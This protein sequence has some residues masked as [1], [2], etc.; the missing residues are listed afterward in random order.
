[1]SRAVRVAA[2]TLAVA[3]VGVVPAPVWAAPAGPVV[4]TVAGTGEQ[5]YTGDGGP[6]VRAG[7]PAPGAMALAPDG[8][9]YV[10]SGLRIRAVAPDGTIRTVAGTGGAGLHGDG[11]PATRATFGTKDDW[12]NGI[13]GIAL[14]PDGTLYVADTDNQRVRAIDPRTH[15]IRTVAGSGRTGAWNGSY[16][17]DDG[18]A[19]HARLSQPEDVAVGRDGTLYIAD[20]VNYRVRAVDPSRHTIRTVVGTRNDGDDGNG[21]FPRPDDSGTVA[22]GTFIEPASLAFG[23]DGTL[24]VSEPDRHRVRAVDLAANRITTYAPVEQ[25]SNPSALTVVGHTLYVVNTDPYGGANQSAGVYAVRLDG[26]PKLTPF[27]GGGP[28][29]RLGEGGSPT[30]TAF[31]GG[32][33]DVAGA[34]TGTVYVSDPGHGRVR[35]VTTTPPARARAR[36]A[37]R[38][39]GYPDRQ[40]TFGRPA[41]VAVAADGTAY[42][43]DADHAEVF[44]VD[45][46]DGDVDVVAGTTDW[47]DDADAVSGD[48]TGVRL[49]LPSDIAVTG[50]TLYVAENDRIRAVDL[51][52][53]TIDAV[54]GTDGLGWSH[55]AIG[56]HGA[57]YV[58][59]QLHGVCVH[60]PGSTSCRVI[61][62][63]QPVLTPEV[64]A[65][66]AVAVGPDGT[67][68][69]AD[70]GRIRAVDARTGHTTTIAGAYGLVPEVD[71]DGGPA[72]TTGAL[73]TAG[74]AVGADGIL[75][76]ADA[77]DSRI[78]AV[79][80]RTGTITTVAGT[81]RYRPSPGNRIL[82]PDSA[83]LGGGYGG[84]GGPARRAKLDQ[85]RD[86]AVGP[87]GALYVADTGNHRI[88]AV[89]DVRVPPPGIPLGW[90]LAGAAVLLLAA[91]V[92]GY[93]RL[94]RRRR[95]TPD[96]AGDRPPP[97]DDTPSD[98]PPRPRADHE[99]H[100]TAM[101]PDG[102]GMAGRSILAD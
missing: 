62:D 6:A 76:V 17:G 94:R 47:P 69:V 31:L 64:R 97:G 86:V 71:A 28:A 36:D 38:I 87:H 54:P 50:H 30:A 23:P 49:D 90:Y 55:V 32:T 88:R 57:L 20:R 53:G 35:A 82:V 74:L 91:L 61:A 68:Y 10:V 92:A 48:A 58:S 21:F 8:T 81:G 9:L 18:P 15:R 41:A 1:M 79:D 99:S 3:L 40:A 65:P 22:T 83:F 4:V 14:A 73:Y 43:L 44:A 72:T 85:P 29:D 42:V 101:L 34:T 2:V 84:D 39:V 13:G 51:T 37:G 98:G 66:G 63:D 19:D 45:P 60:T 26:K 95:P 93:L 16:A 27:A 77:A 59:S 33:V 12:S 52:R 24:F 5:E 70:M 80:T 7:M 96:A 56:P 46:D 67:A 11:G 78:R 102:P 25:L 100:G 89:G 75:Y